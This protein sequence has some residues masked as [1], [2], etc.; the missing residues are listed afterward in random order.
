MRP[1]RGLVLALTTLAV[2]SVA[3]PAVGALPSGTAQGWRVTPIELRRNGDM[4]ELEVRVKNVTN[5]AMRFDDS[6]LTLVNEDGHTLEE[7]MFGGDELIGGTRVRPGRTAH[8]IAYYDPA[9][10]S[11][12]LTIRVP[13]T[14]DVD[15][16]AVK[17]DLEVE[18]AA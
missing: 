14:T 7:A 9:D 3:A 1:T 12:R 6:I 13:K 2:V 18:D 16:P 11:E 5:K 17:W 15:G 10:A 8:G 4:I